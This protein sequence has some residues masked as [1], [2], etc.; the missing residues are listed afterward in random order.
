[1]AGARHYSQLIVWQLADAIRI[2]VF[3]LTAR[4]EFERDFR[5]RTQTDD[6]IESV[7]RNIAEGFGGTNPEFKHFLIIARRSLN[8]L[9]D[10]FRSAQLKHHISGA[11]LIPINALARRL[12]PA[13]AGL[14]RHLDQSA[15]SQ[16]HIRSRRQLP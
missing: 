11:D 1:M 9:F 13:L 15:P 14:I 4:P 5:L 8:E 6:A 16:R 7:C 2:K 12:Y 3:E 10:S